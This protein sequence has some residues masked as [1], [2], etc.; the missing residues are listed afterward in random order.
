MPQDG[1]LE[2]AFC[3]NAVWIQIKQQENVLSPPS[4]KAQS[5][6]AHSSRQTVKQPFELCLSYQAIFMQ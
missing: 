4:I 6:V 5:D 1:H 3:E 2:I